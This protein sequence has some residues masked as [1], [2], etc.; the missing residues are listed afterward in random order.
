VILLAHD[1][2]KG[3]LV[4]LAICYRD[5][6]A[7]HEL[8]STATTGR[9]L[10]QMVGLRPST[11]SA[12]LDGNDE[13]IA[14]RISD[15]SICAVIFLTDP[16]TRRMHEPRL[17]SVLAAC[18]LYDVPLATNVATAGAVLNLVSILAA[19]GSGDRIPIEEK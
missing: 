2:K 3:Q 1:H 13:E 15:P 18:S 17:E 4:D 5:V 16:F 14:E 9:M 7:D 6:L 10:S 8:I 12:G 19:A 11:L